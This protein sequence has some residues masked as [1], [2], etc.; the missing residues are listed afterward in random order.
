M[1]L[2]QKEYGQDVYTGYLTRYDVVPDGVQTE[3]LLTSHVLTVCF[4]CQREGKTTSGAPIK[5]IHT[6]CSWKTRSRKK[7]YFYKDLELELYDYANSQ[8]SSELC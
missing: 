2:E 7:A 4:I 6:T 5:K 1:I 3:T 8:L